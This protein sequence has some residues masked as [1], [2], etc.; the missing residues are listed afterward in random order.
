MPIEDA[1]STA[2]GWND[3]GG[4]TYPKCPLCGGQTSRIKSPKVFARNLPNL[5]KCMH[6]GSISEGVEDGKI[7]Y[8]HG[9]IVDM[10]GEKEDQQ[11]IMEDRY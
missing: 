8:S 11:R 4:R 7:F 10:T 3:F 6:C 5:S 9:Y 2:E 1:S